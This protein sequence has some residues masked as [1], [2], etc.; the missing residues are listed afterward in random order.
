MLDKVTQLLLVEDDE[1]DYILT[2]DYLEQLDS[3][4][5][6]VQWVSSPEQAIETLSKNEHDICLLDYRL[7]ASNGLDVL[8]EAIANGFSGPIIMLTGQSDD[9]LDSAALDAGAVDY[10]IKGEMSSSRF[11][12][13][14]RYALARKDVE[15]ERV[16]RLKA[17]AENRSKDR[18]LAHL[19]HEL[20][21]PLSSILGYTE[22]LMQSDFSQQA[23][24]ELGV[25]YRNGKHL[26]SLLNDVLDLSKIAADKLELTLSEVNLDSML[27]DVYTLMRVSVLDKGLTLRFE[28]DQ[29][30]PLV[31]RLDATRVRQILINL[32]NNAVKFTD[33]GEIVV[34][35][36]TQHVDNK[37]M[38]FF[39]IKDSGMGI[40]P[41]KQQLIFKPFEQIADVESR[42]VGG[43]GLG[44]AIC[45][46]LLSRMQGNISLH[47][48]IGKGSTFTISVYPGDI[49]DVERQV[50]NF[51]SVP[52][53][54]SKLTPS[55]VHGRVLVVDD[56]RD[57]RMLVGHMISSCGARVDYAEHGQQ[58]LEKVRI[59]DAYKAPYDIIFIDIHM[60]VMGGKEATIELR[61]MGYKGPII[62]LTA[63]TMK[64]IH[65]ELAALGFNDVIPKPVDS[66]ALYQ[67]L[68]DY[69]VSPENAPQAKDIQVKALSEKRQR[70]LLV[71]DDDD[72]AQITQLLLESLGVE[73]VIASSCAQCL[74]ILNHDQQFDKVL[75]DM[76]LPDGSG[77]DLGEQVNERYPELRLVIV[78][79]AEPDPTEI[80]DLNIDRVL[81]KPIN[82][83]LLETL[84]S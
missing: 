12:R 14:I 28:S 39:S 30:L 32:I 76:H 34:K 59:A 46:E 44:L 54:Q 22:L 15:G 38:L 25:I 77:I 20:R 58:A 37:E 71:E 11:A 23:E 66:S 8:K 43:A 4:T 83:G 69:L 13:A 81:L 68:Q 40:A 84:I 51:S 64:G 5:F 56:L 17:E 73:T 36:W 6:N 7:G 19:S 67:C 18:F 72:A 60:P 33:K 31:A 16:E 74:Q 62:A 48:E 9:E 10:L 52:Q 63:A 79:G 21:T 50:L 26:L 47:S 53:L 27:A 70:F 45:A 65:E 75:L 29:A 57:L 41:E 1:D 55:K 78:S 24:N 80:K 49:S 35:A 61:K 2:C 82:L 42:S 3:H